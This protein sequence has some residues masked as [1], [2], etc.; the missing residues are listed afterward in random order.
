MRALAE[1]L[2]SNSLFHFTSSIDNL[3]GILESTFKPRYCLESIDFA[4]NTRKEKLE[5]AYPMVCFCD[6]P[7]SK[8]KL[9][10]TKYGKYGIGLK[11][12][13]GA[14]NGLS[15][16]FY[17]DYKCQT[18]KLI[19]ILSTFSNEF[20]DNLMQ[21]TY[22]SYLSRLVMYVKSYEGKMYRNGKYTKLIRF[23]DE[24]EWRWVPEILP[25]NNRMNLTK[26]EFSDSQFR[27][28]MNEN[29]SNSFRL[30]FYPDDIQY[31]VIDN[32]SEIDN[33][34]EKVERIKGRFN[35]ETVKRLTSRII[36][37]EQIISDF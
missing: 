6:I 23:Y 29:I 20:H 15:P 10:L 24:R 12:S 37:R 9:H 32:E 30:H 36:T 33:F 27:S 2:S 31:L 21:M 13:W 4:A 25:G 7:L 22:E 18:S 34:I 14:E 35:P 28:L 26:S 1:N 11:K 8:I 19:E 3:I 5:A 16:V 17:V